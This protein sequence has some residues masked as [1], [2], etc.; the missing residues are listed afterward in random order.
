M[1]YKKTYIKKSGYNVPYY[2]YAWK[3]ILENKLSIINK[4]IFNKILLI[5]YIFYFILKLIYTLQ[6]YIYL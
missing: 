2:I 6:T 4:R 5:C 3:K 1:F